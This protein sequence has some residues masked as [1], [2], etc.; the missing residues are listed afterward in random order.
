MVSTLVPQFDEMVYFY[1]ISIGSVNFI[2]LP[3]QFILVGLQLSKDIVACNQSFVIIGFFRGK[4]PVKNIYQI[5]CRITAYH[6]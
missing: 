1:F 2:K 5:L 6:G 3:L 4:R